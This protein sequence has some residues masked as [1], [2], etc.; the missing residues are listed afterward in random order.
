MAAQGAPSTTT[1]ALAK[2][3]A[4]RGGFGRPI[5][6]LLEEEEGEEISGLNWTETT[7][8]IMRTVIV[9]AMP[10]AQ[11]RCRRMR[12]CSGDSSGSVSRLS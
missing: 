4:S 12:R 2:D 8:T 5:S 9:A 3:A 7:M 1:A 11:S 6:S 10:V